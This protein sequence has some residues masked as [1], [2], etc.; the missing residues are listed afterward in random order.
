MKQFSTLWTSFA[1]SISDGKHTFQL[2]I[3]TLQSSCLPYCTPSSAHFTASPA[4]PLLLD[5]Q[6]LSST[7][8]GSPACYTAFLARSTASS[9]HCTTKPAL[10]T[11]RSVCCSH[12]PTFWIPALSACC[13]VSPSHC[14]CTAY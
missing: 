1:S 2:V 4:H 12:N 9:G 3:C 11:A 6:P 13:T 5:A 7:W 8:S 10:Y 14:Q